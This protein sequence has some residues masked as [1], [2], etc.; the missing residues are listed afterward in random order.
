MSAVARFQSNKSKI[1][2]FIIIDDTQNTQAEYVNY[3][4]HKI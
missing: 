2:A 4:R 3:E 1:G